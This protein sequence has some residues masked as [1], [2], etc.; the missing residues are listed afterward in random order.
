MAQMKTRLLAALLA[1]LLAASAQAAEPE[2]LK[3]R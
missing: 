2:T 3:S 1:L